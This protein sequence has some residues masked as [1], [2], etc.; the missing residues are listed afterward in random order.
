MLLP[1][2]VR[3]LLVGY[4]E[5]IAVL[6]A[7]VLGLSV[8]PTLAWLAEHHGISILLAILVF[9]TAVTIDP[10][11]LRRLT[12]AWPSL[13]V[14]LAAGITVLPALAWAVAQIVG[15]RAAPRRHHDPRPRAVRDRL[16]R[17]H[18]PGRRHGRPGRRGAHR[19]HRHHPRRRA[20]PGARSRP[21]RGLSRPHHRQPRPHRRA[22]AGSRDRAASPRRPPGP[23]RGRRHHHHGGR[24][25]GLF[26]AA[27]AGADRCVRGCRRGAWHR[28]SGSGRPCAGRGQRRRSGASRWL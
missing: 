12:G 9:A 3:L 14:V 28:A 16:G 20:A 24:G 10:A 15:G 4:P 7:A 1:S 22:A 25:Q 23:R 17:H 8:Q 6:A 26:S 13:V 18:R 27:A 11:A 5:L 19:L 2:R 21:R